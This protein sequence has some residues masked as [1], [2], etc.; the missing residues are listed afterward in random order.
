MD[1]SDKIESRQSADIALPVPAVA[2]PSRRSRRLFRFSKANKTD[3]HDGT[4]PHRLGTVVHADHDA[5]AFF[6]PRFRRL[7]SISLKTAPGLAEQGFIEIKSDLQPST[8]SGF[9]VGRMAEEEFTRFLDASPSKVQDSIVR[10]ITW[11]KPRPGKPHSEFVILTV[12]TGNHPSESSAAFEMLYDI[13]LERASKSVGI[14]KSIIYTRVTISQSQPLG[15]FAEDSELIIGLCGAAA[16]RIDSNDVAANPFSTPPFFNTAAL[17]DILD[18]K[19]A[20]APATLWHVGKY[21]KL[22]NELMP[23]YDRVGE[24]LDFLPRLLMDIIGTRHW[25]FENIVGSNLDDIIARSSVHDPSGIGMFLRAV[26]KP[27][28]DQGLGPMKIVFLVYVCLASFGTYEI[29]KKHN[30]VA[31]WVALLWLFGLVAACFFGVVAS[32]WWLDYRYRPVRLREHGLTARLVAAAG[33]SQLT[34]SKHPAYSLI[35]QSL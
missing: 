7:K 10:H 19:W 17:I 15:N 28:V 30:Q 31:L 16:R 27:P 21:L 25:I 3:S 6:L 20:G 35:A 34:F 22:I 11:W 2:G 32:E 8:T 5:G 18:E 4:P 23:Q 14:T 1:L 9:V 29:V 12:A 24:D 26:R 33:T 13:R